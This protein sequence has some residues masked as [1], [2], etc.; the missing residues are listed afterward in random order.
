[1]TAKGWNE[2]P[3]GADGGTCR[4]REEGG[5]GSHRKALAERVHRE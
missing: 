1:M 4:E 2:E 5:R 3:V